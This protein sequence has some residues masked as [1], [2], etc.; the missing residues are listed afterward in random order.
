MG[1]MLSK[2]LWKVGW[3]LG[4]CRRP[5]RSCSTWNGEGDVSC[6][7]WAAQRGYCSVNSTCQSC[8]LFLVWFQ[9]SRLM[10]AKRN[11]N[12]SLQPVHSGF[13]QC[14]SSSSAVYVNNTAHVPRK[15][16]IHHS[17][18]KMH[19]EKRH[20]QFLHL[21]ANKMTLMV[22]ME[23][24]LWQPQHVHSNKSTGYSNKKNHTT[25][26]PSFSLNWTSEGDAV[27]H[28]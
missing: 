9:L 5:P 4:G 15:T 14:F 20:S 8:L 21:S 11:I 19:M 28:M 1:R 10:I 18:Q 6:P 27:I 16:L 17:L 12:K 26:V 22:S 24:Q 2:E 13:V 23:N 25:S 7:A 3:E